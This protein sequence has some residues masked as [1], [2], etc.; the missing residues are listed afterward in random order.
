L[1]SFKFFSAQLITDMMYQPFD[2]GTTFRIIPTGEELV[3][4]NRLP[5]V[6][7]RGAFGSGEHETTQSCLEIL[8]SIP[9]IV[10]SRV[11]DFGC[12]T[13]ILAIAATKLGA[14]RA[15]CL[16]IDH[17][18]ALNARE[19]CRLNETDNV[20]CIAGSISCLREQP[21]D[22]ILANIYG[23]ILLSVAK[24]LSGMARTGTYTVLSGILWEDNFLVRQEYEKYG[25]RVKKNCFMDEYS[26][27]LLQKII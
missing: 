8:E 17:Q 10:G 4:D 24:T 14:N 9:D 27:L 16:D 23:D 18:A 26:S 11:L 7:K 25:F 5:L 13:G 6:M 21:F 20:M 2:I 12:G 19:N 3:A 1:V 22:L 15:V